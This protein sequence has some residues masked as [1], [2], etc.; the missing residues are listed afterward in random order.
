MDPQLT[1]LACTLHSGSDALRFT[2]NEQRTS[3]SLPLWLND[4]WKDQNC[5]QKAAQECGQTLD[6]SNNA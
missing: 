2:L 1:P 4:E 5:V 3:L 6:I